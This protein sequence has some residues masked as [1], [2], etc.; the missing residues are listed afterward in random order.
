MPAQA[1]QF[2]NPTTSSLAQTLVP[3]SGNIFNGIIQCGAA[4]GVT[5][6]EKNKYVNPGPRI[7]FAWDPLGDGKWAVRG[8]YGIFFE[9]A[10]GNEANAESLQN[11]PSPNVLNGVVSNIVGYAN[12]GAAAASGAVSPLNPISIP[13]QVQWPYV[14]QWNLDIQHEL[15]G[16]IVMQVAYVGSRGTHLVQ[17]EDLNQLHPISAANN[18]Y[19]T[20]VPITAGDC[21]SVAASISASPTGF[22]TSATISTG[23]VV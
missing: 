5:G 13:D 3:G 19:P 10:N 16:H 22:P 1:P 23:T 15:P 21:S 6:C 20:G 7:G 17:T 4:N 11:G 2:N 18:P 8:G 14:Q 12:V 9:H